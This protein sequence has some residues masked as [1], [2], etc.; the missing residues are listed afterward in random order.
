MGRRAYG[1]LVPPVQ[2]TALRD[3]TSPT[4]CGAV[5]YSGCTSRWRRERGWSAGEAVQAEQADVVAG[6]AVHGKVR[7]HLAHQAAEL[8]AVAAE[9]RP[10]R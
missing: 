8:V 6:L 9:A 10:R 2:G 7:H 5:Q 3:R 1:D 4:R